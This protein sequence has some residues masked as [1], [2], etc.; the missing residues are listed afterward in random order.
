MEKNAHELYQ[1][2]VQKLKEANK[3]LCRP[4]EDVV[5]YMVCKNSQIAIDSFL[6]GYLL[7]QGIEPSKEATIDELY[8]HCKGVNEHFD[9]IDL[10][11]F[12]CQAHSLESRYCSGTE[13][14]SRCFDIAGSLD[15]F[16]REKKIIS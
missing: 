1:Q 4:E 11:G 9:K 8:G 16:L 5:A 7:Q 12:D 6:R 10:A 13:K 15:S 3:E 2:A 14:V